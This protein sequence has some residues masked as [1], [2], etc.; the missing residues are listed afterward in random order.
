V[1]FVR[2]FFYYKYYFLW[3]LYK[4]WKRNVIITW[5]NLTIGYQ[6]V[7]TYISECLLDLPVRT[8][9]A[10][11]DITRGEVQ[12]TFIQHFCWLR[13]VI[14]I[15]YLTISFPSY[16]HSHYYVAQLLRSWIRFAAED[17][18]LETLESTVNALCIS[19]VGTRIL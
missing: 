8:Y 13:D 2:N 7:A 5:S 12:V 18:N 15:C 9:L 6:H 4:S 16:L 17:N 3:K 10:S 19:I 1:H 14:T 11:R